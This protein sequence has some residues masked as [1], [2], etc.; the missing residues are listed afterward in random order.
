MSLA[1]A[2]QGFTV[3]ELLVA[4][5]LG[6]GLFAITLTVLDVFQRDT[7]FNLLRNET[8]DN[9]RTA[10]DRLARE[11]RNVSAPSVKEAGALEQAESYALTF[12]TINSTPASKGEIEGNVTNAMR[13]RYCLNNS[14]P[15]DEVLWRETV[16][17]KTLL[18]PPLPTSKACPDLNVF[19]WEH[20][21]Q[22]VTNITNRIG[23]QSRA[24]FVYGPSGASLTSQITSVD[25]TVYTDLAPGGEPGERVVNTTI[26]MRNQNRS[27]V[28][29]FTATEVGKHSVYLNASESADPNGLAL[30]YRWWDNGTPLNSTS[31]QYET[32]ELPEGGHT[33]KLEVKNP[34]GLATTSEQVFQVK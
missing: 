19:D 23:G 28:A 7:R 26:Y 5:S 10:I 6:V 4:M 30:S 32:P 33:F 12:Q 2:Q 11:L 17:W 1:R 15:S 25:P 13:V 20:T 8:Q 16:H 34:G 24:L 18:A 22:I 27:P 29:S 9:A 3:V 21:E 31:Q 14:N